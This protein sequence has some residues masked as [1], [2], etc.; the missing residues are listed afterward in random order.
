MGE[1][2]ML[3]PKRMNGAQH[4]LEGG[5]APEPLAPGCVGFGLGWRGNHRTS[6]P[7]G[8]CGGRVGPM[9]RGSERACEHI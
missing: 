7:T 6:M 4:S 3:I 5:P 1:C 8:R 9:D 2:L